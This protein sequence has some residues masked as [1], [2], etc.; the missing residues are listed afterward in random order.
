MKD[1]SLRDIKDWEKK[2]SMK[3]G[4]YPKNKEEAEELLRRVFHKLVEEVG[5]VSSALLREKYENASEE[6]AD[7]II[8][9]TKINTILEEF[10]GQKPLQETLKEKM[11]YCEKRE[12]DEKEKKLTKPK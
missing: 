11:D 12:W 2:F 8:F 10:Y 4:F 3:K 6:L 7:I 9:C 1:L 5:E